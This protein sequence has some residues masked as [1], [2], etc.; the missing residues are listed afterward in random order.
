MKKILTVIAIFI[1]MIF[2]GVFF[3]SCSNGS[4]KMSLSIEYALPTANIE[5]VNWKKAGASGQFDYVLSEDVYSETDSAYVLY[6][7]VKVEGSKKV[8]S[9]YIS[10]SANNSTILENQVV[11]PNEAFKVLIK[12]IGSVKFDVTPSNGG[13]DKSISFNVN[14]YKELTNIEQN[15]SCVPAVVTGGD[16]KLE[17]LNN[18]IK[19]Y[20]LN[21]TNQ[22]GVDYSIEAIGTLL[23]NNDDNL[24]NRTFVPS[25]DYISS[26]KERIE[27][28]GEDEDFVELNSSSGQLRLKIS[29]GYSLTGS[30]NVIKLCAVSKH[31]KNISA[32]IYVYIVENFNTSS[33]LV[34]YS[35]AIQLDDS[36]N[37]PTQ[38]EI[39][40]PVGDNV[41][42][43]NST[44]DNSVVSTSYNSVE[45][46]T[47]TNASIYSFASNPGIVLSVYVNGVL[48]DYNDVVNNNFGIQISP[49][50]RN[51]NGEDK[52]A[53]LKFSVN[54]NS[55]T[56]INEYKIRLE[57]DFTAFD[58]SASDKTP[59]SVL[60]KEFTIKV[61]SLASGFHINGKGYQDNLLNLIN[62]NVGTITDYN[63]T[64]L[65]KLYTSYSGDAIGMP[66]NIQATPTNAV[67]TNV[68]VSFYEGY[69]VLGGNLQ[70]VNNL[71]NKVQLLESVGFGLPSLNG[72]FIV[73]FDTENKLVY[74]KFN[75]GEDVSDLKQIY[76][77]CKVACTP[78]T[79]K[80]E[81]I[82]K[83]YITF[84]A[85]IDVVGAVDKI[86]V[87]KNAGDNVDR[88]TLTDE[89]LANNTINTAYINLNSTS[90][91]VDLSEVNINSLNNN[92]KYSDDGV[93]WVDSI[94]ADDLQTLSG[95]TYKV[96]YFR[97]IQECTDSIIIW[98]ANGIKEEQKYKFVNVTSS[99]DNVE[100]KF[101]DTYIWQSSTIDKVGITDVTEDESVDL[102]YLALQSGR[103]VQFETLADGRNANIKSINAKSLLVSSSE[104]GKITKDGQSLY[105][106][107][108]STFSA[109]AIR[110]SNIGNYLF[111]V[112]ANSVGFT[113]ILL[114]KVNFYVNII[115][116]DGV[117][118]N[119]DD[120]IKTIV[121]K[122]KYFVYEVA[123][124]TPAKDL[125]VTTDKDKITYINN[126]YLSSAI[127]DFEVNLNAATYRILFSSADVNK[128]INLSYGEDSATSIYGISVTASDALRLKDENNN[129]YF[130][131]NGLNSYQYTLDGMTISENFVSNST[132]K[133]SIQA[134]QSLQDLQQLQYTSIYVDITIYQFGVKTI[135]QIR[136]VIYFG[137][138]EKA[139]S[140]I[141]DGVD[142]Y[143][144]IYLSL[145]TPETSTATIYA[146]VSNEGA[147]YK[148]LGYN[149]YLIDNSTNG[150][151]AYEGNNLKIVHN[152]EDGSFE[153]VANGTGGIYQL[154]LYAK[155]SFNGKENEVKFSIRINVSDGQS[156]ATAYL[157]S[158]LNEFVT[159][160]LNTSNYYRL[161]KDIN[162]SALNDENWWDKDRI[163][164]GC[165]DGAITIN[166]PNTGKVIYKCYSLIG[167]NI[168]TES[169]KG[170]TTDNCFGLF[171]SITGTIKNIIFDRVEFNIVL[172]KNN[173]SA[174][175]P[176]NIGAITAINN[177][178][179]ENCSVNIVSSTITLK[180]YLDNS[181]LNAQNTT[182]NIGVLAGVNNK[183]I[184]Y[185]NLNNGS[186]YAYMTDCYAGGRLTILVE[187]GNTNIG[188]NTNIY[189]GG[190]VGKN[191]NNAT[192]SSTYEDGSTQAIRTLITVIANIE[193]KMDYDASYPPMNSN[194]AVG[195]ISGLN[196]GSINN[197]AISGR[198]KVND[199]VNLGGI[200]GENR[201][202]IK[203]CANYGAYIE[204]Y[205]LIEGYLYTY[206]DGEKSIVYH[207]YSD[208]VTTINQEQNIGGIIGFNNSGIVDNVRMMFILFDDNEVSI[209]S[210]RAGLIGVGNIGGIIGKAVNTQL[211][212]GYVENFVA[213]EN[214]LN[215][216]VIGVKANVAGFIAYS[217]NSRVDLSFVQAD[218]NVEGSKF[219]EFGKDLTYTHVYFV[220]DVLSSNISNNE[221]IQHNS[222]ESNSYI[223]NNIIYVDEN[224]NLVKNVVEY[225]V[226]DIV[227]NS[228][229]TVGTYTVQWRKNDNENINNNYPYLVYIMEDSTI[230]TLT[231]RPSDIIVNVDEN[232]FGEED[233]PI[234]RFE[235]YEQQQGAKQ[236]G[237]FIQYKNNDEICATAVV[238][239]VENGN[240]THKLVSN[241]AQKGLIEKTILPTI[242]TGTYSVSIVS[243]AQIASLTDGDET[244]TFY[245]TGKVELRFVSLYDRT[246]QDTVVIFVENPLHID[247]FDITTSAGLQD[248][249]E[250]SERFTT[251]VG[252]N[253]IVTLNM[254]S[255]NGQMFDSG[256]L[257]MN[258]TIGNATTLINS[259][260]TP[261]DSEK[262]T[263]YFTFKPITTKLGE[264]KFAFGQFEMSAKDID[265]TYSYIEIPVTINVYLN[266][267]KYSIG[268]KSLSELMGETKALIEQKT[269][270]IIIYNKATGLTVSGDVKAE[271]G[272]GV[273]VVAQL[274]TG[275]VNVNNVTGYVG[276]DIIGEKG[277]KLLISVSSQDKVNAILTAINKNAQDLLEMAK[278][279]AE[280]YEQ[281]SVWDLFDVMVNYQLLENNKGY[282]YNIN[283][284]LKEAYRYLDL[285]DYDEGEWKFELKVVANSNS[286]LSKLVYIS[287]VPQQ[288]TSFRLENYSNL[289]SRAGENNGTTISEFISNEVESSLII[290]GESGL[291]K[292]FAEYDYSYFENIS[293]TSTRQVVNGTEYFIRY[294]QMV[295]NKETK[296]YESYAGITA[297]GETLNLKKVSYS[298]GSYAG[299]IFVR[300]IL[301][302]IVGVRQTFTITVDATTY[303]SQGNS[304]N[305][306]RSKTVISQ[307]RP[308]V[309]ISVDNVI[310]S[311]YN[312]QAIYLVEENSSVSTIIARVYGYEFNV[313]PIVTIS[314]VNDNDTIS[315]GEV[316]LIKQG[317]ITKD[318]TGA[319][320][321]KYSLAVYTNKPF[322]VSMIMQLIDDGNTLSDTSEQLVFYPVP[323]ILSSV[324]MRGEA[325]GGLN[326]SIGSSKNMELVWN[327]KV[328]TNDKIATI[329]EK[330]K[331]LD[332]L[333]LFYIKATDNSGRDYNKYFN[334]FL[335]SINTSF[336]IKQNND[337]TYR[338][339]ALME[340]S[341]ITV[342]FDLWY[343][344]VITDEGVEVKFSIQ[345]TSDCMNRLHYEFMLNLTM[346][347]T[348]DAP[349][350]INTAEDLMLMSEG[351]NYIL[352]SDIT[353]ER[354]IPLNTAIA[355]LDGNGKV[356]NIKSFD[357]S[358]ESS[359]N[360]GLFGAISK[361]T[362]IKNVV[363]NISS[364]ENNLGTN[365]T[366]LY[367]ND[368]N[369][370]NVSINFGVLAGINNGL[371]YNCEIISINSSRTLEIVVGST[372]SLTFGGLVGVNQGNITNSRVGTEYFEQ[373]NENDGNVSSLVIPCGTLYFKSK[374]IMAGFVGISGANCI[375]SSCYV[376]NTSIENT[377]NNGDSNKN[378]TAGFVAT[379]SGLISYSYV[380][381]LERSIVISK[382]RATDCAIY[383]SGAG[384]VAG[385]AY[386]NDGEIH[387]CYSNIVCKSNSSGVAGFVYNTLNGT[388][389]QC[390]SASIVQ[391][392][393][394][395]TALA[396]E[397]PFVGVG[398]EKDEAKKLLSNSK[399]VN[400]YYLDDGTE[401]DTNYDL[402]DG[403][404]APKGL[405][406][407]SFTN[408]NNLNNYSFINNTSGEQELNGVWTYS[409]AVDKNKSTYGLGFTSLP[410][411]TSANNVS[412]S[413]RVYDEVSST[414]DEKSYKYPLGYEQG[415]SKN[416][417]II[418]S[419]EEY[420]S[421]FV[422]SGA[423]VN[424]IKYQTGYV[425]FID[426]IS[427]MIDGEYINIDTR[428]NYVLGDRNSNTFT[429]I[430]GNGMTISNVII[431]YA[432]EDSGSLGLFS[433]VHYS[434]IK[435][436][437]IEYSSQNTTDDSEVGSSTVTYAGGV[438]G[439]ARNTYFIDL[440]LSGDV[441]LRAHNVVGGVVGRLTGVNSGLY[442]ITTN[443]SVQSGNYSDSN[444][445]INEQTEAR[446]LSYAGGIAG[447]IDIGS[448][449]ISNT[450]FNAN[451]LSVNSS[452]VRANRAGGIAGYLGVNVNA[453]RLTYVISA[454]S[455]VFGREVA[456]GMVA[457]NFANIELSQANRQVGE[458]YNYDKMFAQYINDDNLLELDNGTDENNSP[459]G[460]LSAVTGEHIV[461]G[462]IGVNYAGDVTNSLTKANIGYN[463]DYGIANTIG[464]FIGKTYGGNLKYVY[465]QNYIDLIRTVQDVDDNDVEY[466]ADVVGGL[467][468]EIAYEVADNISSL[469]GESKYFGLDNVVVTNWFDKAQLNNIKLSQK[470]DYLAGIVN[471]E[472]KICKS[473]G[474]ELSNPIIS[475]GVFNADENDE[476]IYQDG[477]IRNNNA[478]E[479][480]F[481]YAENYNMEALYYVSTGND[482]TATSTQQDIFATLF[483]VWP[484]DIW[485]K[486]YT[487]FMPNLKED[488]ATDYIKIEKTE[489]IQLLEQFPDRNFIL[490]ND[491][492][493]GKHSNY[494]VNAEFKGV[495]IGT[496]KENKTYTKFYG[497][498]L[499]A[500]T[501]ND[502][503]AGFFKQTTGARIANINFEYD[504]DVSTTTA[505]NLSGEEYVRVGGVSAYDTN[506]RFEQ[507][508]V[509]QATTLPTASV[510]T[511]S[512]A[513]VVNLGSIVGEA[514]RSKIIS[515]ISDLQYLVNSNKVD[516]NN[517][518]TGNIGGLVGMIN[519]Y[520]YDTEEQVARFDGLI[521]SSTYSGKIS[522]DSDEGVNIGGIVA[523][524]KYIRI[525]DS[526]VSI[527]PANEGEPNE[528]VEIYISSINANYVGG[529]VATLDMCSISSS[530]AHITVLS[531]STTEDVD[532]EGTVTSTYYVGGIVG[533]I[534][535]E[536][537]M[538]K[539]IEY[540][541]A[542][543]TYGLTNA[544]NAYVGGIV[545]LVASN[546]GVNLEGL[547]SDI[548]IATQNTDNVSEL[549]VVDNIIVGGI[550]ALT[551]GNPKFDGI[552][553]VT[554]SNNIAIMNCNIDYN[555]SLIGGGLI[556]QAT[557]SYLINNSTAI[558]QLFANNSKDTHIVVETQP[559]L[560]ILGGLVGLADEL[561]GYIPKGIKVAQTINNSYTTLTLSTA[562]VFKGNVSVE[563]DE[564]GNSTQAISH[565]VYTNAIVGYTDTINKILGGGI[566]YSSDYTLT[567][568]K[569]NSITKDSQPKFENKPLNVTANILL[570]NETTLKPIS[571]DETANEMLYGY[572]GSGWFWKNGHLPIP[573][574]LQEQLIKLSI[575]QYNKNEN[576][577]TTIVYNADN[578]GLAY[579]PIIIESQEDFNNNETKFDGDIYKYYL[580]LTDIVVTNS[581]GVL[582]GV[583]LGNNVVANASTSLLT[584]ITKHSGVSNLTFILQEGFNGKA[585][586]A[587]T[588]D[589]TIFMVGVQYEDKF[590]AINSFGGIAS[591]NNGVISNCY[592]MG[593]TKANGN[594][595]GI[596]Y[597]N[598][599]NASIEDSYFSG[600]FSGGSNGSALVYE[601]IGYI[602]NCYSA[603]MAKD[604]IGN[605]QDSLE[606]ARYGGLYFDYYANYI[607]IQDYEHL[608]QNGIIGKST[609]E[610]QSV[611]MEN[612]QKTDDSAL[613]SGWKV[614][615]IHNLYDLMATD[616]T[617]NTTYN[618]GYPIHDIK[619]VTLT[620]GKIVQLPIRIKRTGNGTFE[621]MVDDKDNFITDIIYLNN[622]IKGKLVSTTYNDAEK[623]NIQAYYDN[624]SFL[625]NNIG[626][627]NL[628]N[629]VADTSNTYFEL[630]VDIVLP[631]NTSGYKEDG[632]RLLSNWAGIGSLD[633]P[634]VG[635][636]N[637]TSLSDSYMLNRTLAD[638]VVDEYGINFKNDAKIME[639]SQP[640]AITNLCGN[641]LFNY[642][643]NGAVIANIVLQ[644]S[645]V[646]TAPLIE[647][648]GTTKTDYETQS[649]FA[650][651]VL[652]VKI[653]ETVVTNDNG[654][655][656]GLVNNINQGDTLN[657]HSVEYGELEIIA[658]NENNGKRASAV[659]GVINTNNGIVNIKNSF[660]EVNITITN[661]T[662]TA[663]AGFI[664][665]NGNKD[666]NA[667]DSI[668]NLVTS[669]SLTL[670]SKEDNQQSINGF[671]SQ[672]CGEIQTLNEN[673]TIKIQEIGK[674]S[675]AISGLVGLMNSGLIAG[676]E[677]SFESAEED[678]YQ[679]EVFGG[680]TAYLN[681]GQL[682]QRAIDGDASA[683]DRSIMV[684]LTTATANIYGG[685]VAVTGE[686]DNEIINTIGSISNVEIK[687]DEQ[688]TIVAS[689]ES[690]E[691]AYGLVI[692]KY[693]S[694]LGEINYTIDNGITFKVNKGT[695]V[696]AIIGL[697]SVGTF[698]FTN[699]VPQIVK[700]YGIGNVGG[701]IGQ[702]V[703]ETSL[704]MQGN[705]WA[706]DDE[707]KDGFAQVELFI[708]EAP[709]SNVVSMKS[710][711]FGGLIGYWNST[712]ELKCEKVEEE[713]T[714]QIMLVN[715]NNVLTFE[716]LT[717]S[718]E[719]NWFKNIEK[720]DRNYDYVLSNIGGIVGKSNASI[721]NAKNNGI[722]GVEI[723]TDKNPHEGQNPLYGIDMNNIEN[724][725]IINDI[726]QFIYIGGVVGY[727]EGEEISLTDCLNTSNIYGMYAV[728]GLVGCSPNSITIYYTNSDLLEDTSSEAIVLG[729]SD[730]GG[731]M[732]KAQ[733]FTII[734]LDESETE[735]EFGKI[736]GI[737]NVGGLVGY[738]TTAN[739]TNC[740]VSGKGS[741]MGNLNVGGLVGYATTGTLK[742]SSVSGL[743]IY[744]TVFDYAYSIYNESL[745][746][747]ELTA[748]YYLPTNIGGITG[749]MA[750]DSRFSNVYTDADV[751]TDTSYLINNEEQECT[752]N[753]T[754]NYLGNIDGIGGKTS[755]SIESGKR[756]ITYLEGYYGTD[757]TD[758]EAVDGGIGG[759]A[760]KLDNPN[761]ITIKDDNNAQAIA[762][763]GNYS[764]CK[765]IGNVY[766]EFGIN[767]GGI[768][769]CLDMS[770]AIAL[771]QLPTDTASNPSI[772]V[773]GKLFVGGYIG[774]SKGFI[775]SE[776]SFFDV[777]PIGYVKVQRYIE[778]TTN[779]EEVLTGNAI[780]GIIGYSTGNV[781]NIKLVGDSESKIK[782]F[783]SDGTNL[784]SNYVGG[785]V[786]RLDGNMA[787]CSISATL[788]DAVN[789]SIDEKGDYIPNYNIITGIIQTPDVYNYGG[790]VGLLDVSKESYG[791]HAT[792]VL[793]THYYAFTVDLV[794]NRNYTQGQSEYGYNNEEF[795][796]LTA[797][798]HYINQNDIKISVSALKGLYNN[799]N[800]YNPTNKDA[801]GWAKEYTMFRS[802]ARIEEQPDEPT[803]DS[804]Q[805]LYSADYITEVKVAYPGMVGNEIL[806]TI[807]KPLG[808]KARLYCKYGI[809]TQTSEPG[810]INANGDQDTEDI[811]ELNYQVEI[812]GNHWQS[813]WK[814]SEGKVEDHLHRNAFWSHISDP[815]QIGVTGDTLN[816]YNWGEDKPGE[817][818]NAESHQYTFGFSYYI[819]DNYLD[820]GETYF[821]FE[822]VYGF[823]G[824]TDNGVEYKEDETL[825]SK[826]GSLF[827]VSGTVYNPDVSELKD[828]YGWILYALGAIFFIVIG[829]LAAPGMIAYISS[830]LTYYGITFISG[831]AISVALTTLLTIGSGGLIYKAQQEGFSKAQSVYTA[832]ED[833]SMGYLGST[834]V[835]NIKWKD[836]Q[837][838]A[839]VDASMTITVPVELNMDI[840]K[841][842]QNLNS[843]YQT[844]YDSVLI[845][846]MEIDSINQTAKLPLTY[847]NCSTARAVPVN[848]NQDFITVEVETMEAGKMKDVLTN[849]G[850][851]SFNAPRFMIKDNELYVY[852]YDMVTAR[853]LYPNYEYVAEHAGED[854]FPTEAEMVVNQSGYAYILENE[855]NS[856]YVI[857]ADVNG[858]VNAD[859]K[860]YGLT[861]TIRRYAKHRIDIFNDGATDKVDLNDLTWKATVGVDGLAG[862][863]QL[864]F[865]G[866]IFRYAGDSKPEGYSLERRAKIYQG[867]YYYQDDSGSYVNVDGS[868]DVLADPD[869]VTQTTTIYFTHNG[870]GGALTVTLRPQQGGSGLT[871]TEVDSISG[872]NLLESYYYI[873]DSEG[874]FNLLCNFALSHLN[875][876]EVQEG[877]YY[878]YNNSSESL[879][880]S[881]ET[882][883][884]NMPVTLYRYKGDNYAGENVE[885]FFGEAINVTM[886]DVY[887]SDINQTEPKYYEYSLSNIVNN[888][889][890]DTYSIVTIDGEQKL[891][892]KNL[893]TRYLVDHK[894]YNLSD[895]SIS[896]I[897]YV[898]SPIYDS[899][900]MTANFD[901][902]YVYNCE[903]E[904]GVVKLYTRY[905][906]DGVYTNPNTGAS[907]P[908][909][910]LAHQFK[911]DD[912][913]VINTIEDLL[914]PNNAYWTGNKVTFAESVRVSL[915]TA[916]QRIYTD[917]RSGKYM[918][919]STGTIEAKEPSLEEY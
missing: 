669:I 160:A 324:Y 753:M 177:G 330:V 365:Q 487:K 419:A 662:M 109:S 756:Y 897:A 881:D 626:V 368:E 567:F 154:E 421:V 426:N 670:N 207:S 704:I 282:N 164:R 862:P 501:D 596:A 739:V 743:T 892:I 99:A 686:S 766:A 420:K 427:F 242:A 277:D 671:V 142:N 100:I 353:L 493:V 909:V 391:S 440:N 842:N 332:Y 59:A 774:K 831:T 874:D 43:Y 204:G 773:A 262:S 781:Y 746:E 550:I 436:L 598:S 696:G 248:R 280:N 194:N 211:I 101:E 799:A 838:I 219:Y 265:P 120:N 387:D 654:Y 75:K 417:Y 786:G 55:S 45:M 573:S 559:S 447:I 664:N 409:T 641:A 385:F 216:N 520:Y 33:L 25:T 703:G 283:L 740:T 870:Y 523:N 682:G 361:D 865:T 857:Q 323:Y 714:S 816:G 887:Q 481:K 620:D 917:Y 647:H 780:G 896:K 260:V 535:S 519:G 396:T 377:S 49:L 82:D 568:E 609:L 92:I 586:V 707:S 375:I 698:N 307:Y 757:K 10:Q 346:S 287:F 730:I 778:E 860:E 259:V 442:N 630:E 123:V 582:N 156:E 472:V 11:K 579:Y 397:L 864:Q 622:N 476:T 325:N 673:S 522:V 418:R 241:D 379:N 399:M 572:I 556:G 635:I 833:M 244:I 721:S 497:I 382:A 362:I 619:Q 495:L 736:I 742:N 701:L 603:G 602:A 431:N 60:N 829:I 327:T 264:D 845:K 563:E 132:R 733:S 232:Y 98:S 238:Y 514:Y 863:N 463:N 797:N 329:N 898:Y 234:V 502:Q 388:V 414:T 841:Y 882:I 528:N 840:S 631:D 878:V 684:N 295:Y 444:R 571:M 158:S 133:F 203:E 274:T 467:V 661:A 470:I 347:T 639:N 812:D 398:I 577:T 56:L 574:A 196:L 851:T 511:V 913:S 607:T 410:E 381:G 902:K 802:L 627:L 167:L 220:G 254:K 83:K 846:G 875:G 830:I 343:G 352:M 649:E 225:G 51:E 408:S 31:H 694:V 748:F 230:Y 350:P 89:F 623:G 134:L 910:F 65:A 589:G 561:N 813:S 683:K 510:Q 503:G 378:R 728:G 507:I 124:Y 489:D 135:Q 376:A 316:A 650:P 319:Y 267:D 84:V 273:D 750:G 173:S 113:A 513:S 706:I 484:F 394:T 96:L 344:Y 269:I 175:T 272:V 35:D 106:T 581:K 425:R 278:N 763:A 430:D 17:N 801:K 9:L 825:Y 169:Y 859:L 212:R 15:S 180:S 354:W 53:G 178:T 107:A 222:V 672:N 85:K 153:I 380:K 585:S 201:G 689:T 247:T 333:K 58:F 809:A 37:L 298:D 610:M 166:D 911:N 437:N 293:I 674:V 667:S 188:Q 544:N 114:V 449:D 741:V 657:L 855:Q 722:L 337:G 637:T 200:S 527:P 854:G 548:T 869:R 761:F 311:E 412:R 539:D 88:H 439:T 34:S 873:Y 179:I 919:M 590:T 126:N 438:A 679:A 205:S 373:L 349:E 636:F 702:Y 42:I 261:I 306:S 364:L 336:S 616:I 776:T 202:T 39:S 19:Y 199:K 512:N 44:V 453:K 455:Q 69:E 772:N 318:N 87:Y 30:N 725:T 837:L 678:S 170:L 91:I 642:V 148:D 41:I 681:G 456:G 713:E 717:G 145:L 279:T 80:S 872:I 734:V 546:N 268:D 310:S 815:N 218:F 685:V 198:L 754:K 61:E 8:K 186:N 745:A 433:E 366:A 95:G 817:I 117:L 151:I 893:D 369:I 907:E 583:I 885:D 209:E 723:E 372:Y 185:D 18:L 315:G 138:Y 110:V 231:I 108:I 692:G 482:A 592:N 695:N 217:I 131:I 886:W 407:A 848:I 435:G 446:Y 340:V 879:A 119:V 518:H 496:L 478:G 547:V 281:F 450:D 876:F 348:E 832:I 839:E 404:V 226:E 140:I 653:K 827:E 429:L 903:V 236:D 824:Y 172:D 208:A 155:D 764:E 599:V 341:P 545:G 255:V 709:E 805:V 386:L 823:I 184:S 593:N 900:E 819:S 190:V 525:N 192:I 587:E 768:V 111:D 526:S 471:S 291:V 765:T 475:Y 371:I 850:I 601:N 146:S 806:Y 784:D 195:G 605:L 104:Y 250:Q 643:E 189:I 309:Y 659:A 796:G 807:Y 300:T 400:C 843:L 597:I 312:N 163:F 229:F 335:N 697:A 457:D 543:V 580:L 452:N 252:V 289:I 889:I 899:V 735:I 847:F 235:R 143:N 224:N 474:S 90:N 215:Y 804:L 576:G 97:T 895:G 320:I 258:A 488:S 633:N 52:L 54:P 233:E 351:E 483:T 67:D 506:S 47:Y 3:V 308:G 276:Y 16:V 617:I 24:V 803:G 221:L 908:M 699:E 553:G 301:D 485:E 296:M 715:K 822:V 549:D 540:S 594:V 448:N 62:G 726:M 23:N 112:R 432:D 5:N 314:P 767:V 383:A 359:M 834:Y 141:V 516:E 7:R 187:K 775:S 835:R 445:Y 157:I 640:K 81:T 655:I 499:N 150:A 524:A 820:L 403:A 191:S 461:G 72:E 360:V 888:P 334:S 465:A 564:N 411:L 459:Y 538:D 628:I 644:N 625:I 345:S 297:D 416:P 73:D 256:K 339:E 604:F 206:T 866:V 46:Y 521:R 14:I 634:F 240:N 183:I 68:Y 849:L 162:I 700:V 214:E 798:A 285:S 239:Y 374:G 152:P 29:D 901:N 20:P 916:G 270:T 26:G 912:G 828:K 867:I 492:K 705:T 389:L 858:D 565:N 468:G 915:S 357:L 792:K 405:S 93:E 891:L 533:Q 680:V 94:T 292:I 783:N 566:L 537:S 303:D 880:T 505:I 629:V 125:E 428:S 6:L 688:V 918:L 660:T 856:D 338:I 193:L 508:E 621:A 402:I 648:V 569:D 724:S 116:A 552:A 720:Q 747:D 266:F 86:F 871:A 28:R 509:R 299:V 129:S 355:S 460:N 578:K 210:A 904:G 136:K 691:N 894:T 852:G 317:D 38:V 197:V 462:F 718:P 638:E 555:N 613:L 63:S 486:D 105:D 223:I 716:E 64:Q 57:L 181:D 712:A 415:S 4:K 22:T 789:T 137:D 392:G 74:L 122:S 326:I 13:E 531:K 147:T 477:I 356:I 130:K 144:N 666:Q 288:L 810:S 614:Y 668:I 464:G 770:E 237:L 906:Y 771:P 159:I 458:Q 500:S 118:G 490:V 530:S 782:V 793:G 251:Q 286:E 367:I 787:G 466:Y 693:N 77:V 322:N 171:N 532:N 406:L 795:K 665:Q 328:T 808:Q 213:D 588:N 121:E 275:Y 749:Y 517:P 249:T 12:N 591:T 253:S 777:N 102:K 790:L 769:G 284:R 263:E 243:G 536:S 794:Q 358:I 760:G 174:N 434:V 615:S 469:E 562:G 534:V 658:Y 227:L 656:S 395:N 612:G 271:S 480:H 791:D 575:L 719:L 32:P 491:V 844:G 424:S 149:L 905:I 103:M 2:G 294:Q 884:S 443:L 788:C 165:L 27:R 600:S 595:G 79:F 606:I 71:S 1:S 710:F 608:E 570:Y 560:T 40:K 529:I 479:N 473:S 423:V 302:N 732:G 304:V 115:N 168:T 390:Y 66:L 755:I 541:T 727:I 139:E 393:S 690:D 542:R 759:F 313:Q 738:A 663:V 868:G 821:A 454:D 677:V 883:L 814:D 731:I 370:S 687:S 558:G 504:K 78:D 758:Y 70:L 342:Y 161:A 652:N 363:I 331:E 618:Y 401:Y 551:I 384:S 762:E 645:K 752:V 651:T 853:M 811:F 729:L 228:N 554:I 711:N 451:K 494:V 800:D 877:S 321:I 305:V 708:P 413:F 751:R 290:P 785:L 632:N 836:G 646:N 48:Y 50:V 246:V 611:I 36:G 245:G 861:R 676:F 890:K 76:M 127:V 128:T 675:T 515:C 176:V 422:N 498:T 182:Y 441:T 624:Q 818:E 584:E 737:V 557:G 779:E 744:G 914:L 826:S 21:E 257:Y